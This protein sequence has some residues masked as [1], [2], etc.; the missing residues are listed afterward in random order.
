MLSLNSNTDK[1]ML[2]YKLEIIELLLFSENNDTG[3][4]INKNVNHRCNSR[5]LI[6][7]QQ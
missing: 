4:W 7:S 5:Y 6:F 2:L 1:A 3:N